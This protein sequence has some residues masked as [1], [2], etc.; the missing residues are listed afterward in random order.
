VFY[1][2]GVRSWA[3]WYT[4]I[5]P[6]WGGGGWRIPGWATQQI[7]G[8]GQPELLGVTLS[9]KRKRKKEKGV[10]NCVECFS[11]LVELIT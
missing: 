5:I 7:Q 6:A 3:L 10:W 2:K 11:A 1:H 4:P 8:Q 9:Q